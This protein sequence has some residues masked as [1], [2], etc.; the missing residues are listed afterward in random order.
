VK[1]AGSHEIAASRERVWDAMQDPAVL[2]RTLPGC[3][4]LEVTGPDEYAATVNAGVASVKGI[5]RGS[6]RLTDQ[7]EPERY[8]LHARGAG[9]PGTIQ[10]E[11]EVRLEEKDDATVVHY[12]ADAVV[13]GMIGGVGQRMLVGVA[14]KT[15]GE[16]FSAVEQDLVHGPVVAEEP[17]AAGAPAEAAAPG[18]REAAPAPG[19]VFSRPA[20]PAA[21]GSRPVE[22]GLAVVLGAAIALIGVA[23]GRRSVRRD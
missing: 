19:Q 13:G 10:A 1:I 5:Y 9:G 15:A 23:V 12:D 6:V 18:E 16:F 2:A 11:A 22:L 4:S 17:A 8:T 14:K 7:Q 20:A 21:E 3:Q